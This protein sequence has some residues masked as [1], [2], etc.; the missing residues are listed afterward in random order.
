MI[1]IIITTDHMGANTE[2]DA[3]LSPLVNQPTN[4]SNKQSINEK[5]NQIQK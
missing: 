4:Q 5:N 2:T 1:I 3:N